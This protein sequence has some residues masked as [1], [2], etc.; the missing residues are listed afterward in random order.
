VALTQER[1]EHVFALSEMYRAVAGVTSG[2][3]GGD[4]HVRTGAITAAGTAARVFAPFEV[5]FLDLRGNLLGR[6]VCDLL[7]GAVRDQV[8]FSGY[9][10]SIEPQ[11]HPHTW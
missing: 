9:R 2:E 6:P 11:Y 1:I 7:G 10:Q 3:A 4:R 5:A 8:P